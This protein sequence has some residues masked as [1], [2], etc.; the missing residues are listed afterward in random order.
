L[1]CRA[2][3]IP[4]TDPRAVVVHTARRSR[5]PGRELCAGVAKSRSKR[6]PEQFDR[7]QADPAG[8]GDRVQTAVFGPGLDPSWQPPNFPDA[9]RAKQWLQD[10]LRGCQELWDS[11]Q[12]AEAMQRGQGALGHVYR[13]TKD[14]WDWP[15]P[16]APQPKTIDG[17]SKLIGAALKS[18]QR[19]NLNVRKNL[20]AG[21]LAPYG[22][23]EERDKAIAL[24]RQLFSEIVAQ[25]GKLSK[26]QLCTLI[27]DRSGVI[28]MDTK[29]AFSARTIERHLKSEFDTWPRVKKSRE[30]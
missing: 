22:S 8:F 18:D 15:I 7:V 27:S 14:R 5:S 12:R 28:D 20:A 9:H 21:P 23:A 6:K 11:G 2:R 29:K 26:R 4:R 16:D 17:L 13:W 24:W 25:G 1:F 3:L 10:E 30:K 19:F